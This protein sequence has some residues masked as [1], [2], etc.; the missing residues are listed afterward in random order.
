MRVPFTVATRSQVT[1]WYPLQGSSP[2]SDFFRVGGDCGGS[3]RCLVSWGG[4]A[5]NIATAVLDPGSY[6][7][8]TCLAGAPLQVIEPPV[9]PPVNTSCATAAVIPFNPATVTQPRVV[10][11]DTLYFTIPAI[12]DGN[13]EPNVFFTT[14]MDAGQLT[15]SVLTNCADPSSAAITQTLPVVRPTPP[16]GI[17]TSGASI[18]TRAAFARDPSLGA[19]TVT[20]AVYGQGSL[21]MTFDV[22]HN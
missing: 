22:S 17:Q 14:P 11:N 2:A 1:T 12:H 6:Y 7:T 18:D 16:S 8:D 13:S 20:V 5:G 3:P 21:G 15:V 9:P 10:T 19:I 4:S